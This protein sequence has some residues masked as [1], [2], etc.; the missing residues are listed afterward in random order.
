MAG[1]ID[2]TF[3]CADTI[4]CDRNRAL[5]YPKPTTEQSSQS[6]DA[7]DVQIE[8]LQKQLNES[9]LATLAL[10]VAVEELLKVLI[11]KPASILANES[12]D[13]ACR[14]LEAVVKSVKGVVK[15]NNEKQVG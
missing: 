7:R 12:Y 14:Q 9:R 8:A 11:V 13:R 2:E 4:E 5:R 10:L 3:I 6:R 1:T 15:D